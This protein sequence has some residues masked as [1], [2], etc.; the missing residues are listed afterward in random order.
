MA[1]V[2]LVEEARKV[3]GVYE[4]SAE[5]CWNVLEDNG[6][7]ESERV[8]ALLRLTDSKQKK[9]LSFWDR[10]R[11]RKIYQGAQ[12]ETLR[13]RILQYRALIEQKPGMRGKRDVP[14]MGHVISETS[15]FLLR[16]PTEAKPEKKKLA[17]PTRGGVEEETTWREDAAKDP[18]ELVNRLSRLRD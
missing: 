7:L 10:R 11:L 1:R 14:E 4:M 8:A 17:V 18:S 9:E 2:T 3:Q 16:V 6:R 13:N 5:D 12:S 15:W